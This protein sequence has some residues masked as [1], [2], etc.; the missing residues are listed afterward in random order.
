MTLIQIC[1]FQLNQTKQ[2]T[3]RNEFA[4]QTQISIHTKVY[5][6]YLKEAGMVSQIL[7]PLPFHNKIM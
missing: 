6:L 1:T 2:K 7:E 3:H 4:P 5:T